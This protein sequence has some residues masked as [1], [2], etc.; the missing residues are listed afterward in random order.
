MKKPRVKLAGGEIAFALREGAYWDKHSVA[1]VWQQTTPVEMTVDLQT[2]TLLIHLP[3]RLASRLEETAKR[4][5]L[6]VGKWLTRM[7]ERELAH[8]TS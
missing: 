4:Q 3:T 6:S 8:T 5:R 1:G 2:S 7:V